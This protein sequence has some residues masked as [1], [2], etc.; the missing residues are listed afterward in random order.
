MKLVPFG[1]MGILYDLDLSIFLSV[2]QLILPSLGCCEFNR[3]N[4]K[5]FP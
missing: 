4:F 2:Y 5:S 1:E 3:Y